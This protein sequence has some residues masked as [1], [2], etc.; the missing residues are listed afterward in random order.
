MKDLI[1]KNKKIISIGLAVIS[2]LFLVLGFLNLTGTE[3]NAY[4]A[5]YDANSSLYNT[6]IDAAGM[7][8]GYGYSSKANQYYS[9]AN[10]LDYKLDKYKAEL[11]KLNIKLGICIALSGVSV[12]GAVLLLK[13]KGDLNAG[14]STQAQTNTSEE[15]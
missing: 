2:I 6:Y 14:I 7:Y 4:K 3:R 1:L 11:T 8:G 12:V 5:M 10:S 9:E 15:K 13:I